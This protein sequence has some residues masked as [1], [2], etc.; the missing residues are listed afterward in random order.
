MLVAGVPLKRGSPK[1]VEH[2]DDTASTIYGRDGRVLEIHTPQD[3]LRRVHEL[4]HARSSDVKRQNR[5]YKGVNN[6]VRNL[7]EDCVIHL[8]HWPWRHAKTPERIERDVAEYLALD[9]DRADKAKQTIADRTAK[10]AGQAVWANFAYR[11]RNAAVMAGIRRGDYYTASGCVG[12][13]ETEASFARRVYN[14]ILNGKEGKA[15]EMLQAAFFPPPPVI[16]LPP[17]KKPGKG[18]IPG[19]GKRATGSALGPKM[20]IIELPH[21]EAIEDAVVGTRIATS[22]ARLY[23]PALR[24][25]VIPS[26]CFVRRSPQEPGGTILVDASGSMGGWDQVKGWCEKSPFGTIAYYAGDGHSKGWLYVYARD[27][28]R[29]REI[30]EPD[31]QGNTVDGPAMDWLMSQEA[32][33]IMVT[34]RGFCDVADSMT[35]VVRL[36]NFE[37]R[38][39]I[40]VVNY[41]KDE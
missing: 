6:S 18:K 1:H 9:L 15:A 20:E 25:P 16:E 24:K 21:T 2:F 41:N 36:E 14:L 11:L 22:G 3:T 26:R 8:K 31:S 19:D 34:D 10:D 40:T 39:E 29:A 27:G 12:F 30:V 13:T 28:M 5:Q 37:A 32:P 7:T 23:R 38:G 17:G 4:M 35:Q 33:R